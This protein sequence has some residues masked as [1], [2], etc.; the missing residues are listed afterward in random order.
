M[1]VTSVHI[2][3]TV[4]RRRERPRSPPNLRQDNRYH[5][6]VKIIYLSSGKP[7]ARPSNDGEIAGFVDATIASPRT[8]RTAV[9][10]G[11]Q[12]GWRDA[13]Q[14]RVVRLR[15]AVIEACDLADVDNEQPRLAISIFDAQFV[16]PIQKYSDHAPHLSSPRGDH[17][18]GNI[19]QHKSGR[20]RTGFAE[21][22]SYDAKLC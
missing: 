11:T 21:D 5:P 4:D 19:Y 13:P 1:L 15:S 10:G 20:L 3:V 6:I 18:R 9:D 12:V 17:L 2:L 16:S 22:A 7:L 14:D 8:S